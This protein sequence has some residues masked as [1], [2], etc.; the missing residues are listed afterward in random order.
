MTLVSIRTRVQRCL[1]EDYAVDDWQPA[2]TV[3]DRERQQ[4]DGLEQR[5][6]EQQSASIRSVGKPPRHGSEHNAWCK[7]DQ[8]GDGG[9]ERRPCLG[10]DEDRLGDG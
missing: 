8:K 3:H 10:V 7:L 5:E 2:A 1:D 6:N 9:P 4:G